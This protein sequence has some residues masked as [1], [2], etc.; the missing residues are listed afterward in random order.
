MSADSWVCKARKETGMNRHL[1]LQNARE[2]KEEHLRVLHWTNYLPAT[3]EMGMDSSKQ[4]Q[5][6]H[7]ALCLCLYLWQGPAS[8]LTCWQCFC[9]VSWQLSA[10]EQRAQ[11]THAHMLPSRWSRH[12]STTE[13]STEEG[14]FCCY[15]T[16][17]NVID[18]NGS[19]LYPAEGT[20]ATF[21]LLVAGCLQ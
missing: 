10:L 11:I 16:W 17:I 2:T 7:T 18:F 14:S 12:N 21:W 1:L 13:K 3:D 20:T 9:S 4:S 5:H 19:Y 8:C 15:R 6:L